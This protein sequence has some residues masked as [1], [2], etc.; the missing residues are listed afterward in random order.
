MA[1][2]ALILTPGGVALMP[3]LDG[4][5]PHRHRS[6]VMLVE[7]GDDKRD[8]FS[9]VSARSAPARLAAAAEAVWFSRWTAMLAVAAQG[10]FA[11]SL[12]PGPA[13]LPHGGDGATPALSDLF[14]FAPECGDVEF[15]R[16]PGWSACSEE[17]FR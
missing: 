10:A 3:F 14:A 4:Q 2:R 16:L 8:V 9:A 13:E 1:D 6:R 17:V 7:V 5:C 12:L 11:E 15:S